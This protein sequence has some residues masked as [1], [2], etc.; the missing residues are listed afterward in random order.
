MIRMD[1]SNN[2]A[3]LALIVGLFVTPIE[4]VRLMVAHHAQLRYAY[5]NG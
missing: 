3:E 1:E 4:H 5:L 2:N